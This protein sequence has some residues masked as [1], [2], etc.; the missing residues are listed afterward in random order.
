MKTWKNRLWIDGGNLSM[1]WLAVENDLMAHDQSDDFGEF[2]QTQTSENLHIW[3][4]ASQICF[5]GQ[6][7][8]EGLGDKCKWE[9]E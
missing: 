3:K 4:Y 5:K 8:K 1:S 7:I 9:S 6:I 2:P